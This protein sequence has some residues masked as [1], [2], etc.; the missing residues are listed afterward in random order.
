MENWIEMTLSLKRKI[1][2][3]HGMYGGAGGIKAETGRKKDVQQDSCR[4]I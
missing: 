2:Y 3:W 1:W 4:G